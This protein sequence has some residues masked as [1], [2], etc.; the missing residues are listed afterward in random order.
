MCG[1]SVR[2]RLLLCIAARSLRCVLRV[3]HSRS[4]SETSDI[5]PIDQKE[6]SSGDQ[7]ELESPRSVEHARSD[8]GVAVEQL[9]GVTR[10]L[11]TLFKRGR[12]ANDS[13][14]VAM[15]CRTWILPSHR[16][17]TAGKATTP[18]SKERSI[19]TQWH[20][21]NV[22]QVLWIVCVFFDARF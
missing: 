5:L 10:D 15:E 20:H 9:C 16:V 6:P 2:A 13:R 21:L 3:D 11:T 17:E 18:H 7:L 22:Q 12:E 19:A 14:Y 1:A 4:L 8:D